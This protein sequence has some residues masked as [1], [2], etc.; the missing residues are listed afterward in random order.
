MGSVPLHV[1]DCKCRFMKKELASLQAKLAAAN[2]RVGT[3]I[4]CLNRSVEF[5]GI[6]Y[7]E[8]AE[9]LEYQQ[10]TYIL[11][12]L[13]IPEKLPNPKLSNVVVDSD[14]D[15]FLGTEQLACFATNIGRLIWILPTQLRS[16]YEISQLA[17]RRTCARASDCNRLRSL[18]VATRS[19]PQRISIVR[20]SNKI[21]LKKIA[22]VDAGGSERVKEPLKPRDQQCVMVLLAEAAHPGTAS[23]ATIAYFAS[24]GIARM[25]HS[26]F[27]MEAVAGV[28]ALGI[29]L[30]IRLGVGEGLRGVCPYF[31]DREERSVWEANLPKKRAQ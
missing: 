20:L 21:G 23:K 17:R 9:G 22:V 8:S 1:D 7:T 12:K 5:C 2:I 15:Y 4:L 10:D 26:S 3:L 29:Y 28:A 6:T 24:N 13:Q 19:N 25:C 18:I 30:N 11:N 14:N 27:D 31:R 16:A